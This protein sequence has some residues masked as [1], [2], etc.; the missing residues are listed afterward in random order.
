MFCCNDTVCSENIACLRYKFIKHF[1]QQFVRECREFRTRFADEIRR[2]FSIENIDYRVGGFKAHKNA[3]FTIAQDLNDLAVLY[4][5]SKAVSK[6]LPYVDELEQ[7]AINRAMQ[8]DHQI[9]HYRVNKESDIDCALQ[10]RN[11]YY[12]ELYACI[13][14]ICIYGRQEFQD[15]PRRQN[16]STIT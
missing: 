3:V 7:E 5:K 6:V 10:K 11:M 14:E 4:R 9:A 13:K 1:F 12:R 2:R 16:Y 15:D 8:L